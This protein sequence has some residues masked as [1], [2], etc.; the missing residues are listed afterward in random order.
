M[1]VAKYLADRKA[2]KIAKSIK[3]K[4]R[5]NR[6]F[7]VRQLDDEIEELSRTVYDLRR[8]DFCSYVGYKSSRVATLATKLY[9]VGGHTPCLI[10]FV[11]SFYQDYELQ[12]FLTQRNHTINIS[13]N[14]KIHLISDLVPIKGIDLN[15]RRVAKDIVNLFNL[16]VSAKP[17]I[18]FLY[19]HNDDV[20]A[21]AVV[22]LLRQKSD[23]KIIFFNHSDH[24]PV[25][26]M[27]F[28]HLILDA[29]SAAQHI[30]QEERGYQNSLIMPLQSQ[31]A[32]ANIYYSEDRL[33]AKRRELGIQ[34]DNLFTLSGFSAYKIFANDASPYISMIRDLLMQEPELKHVLVT[35]LSSKQKAILEEV[36]LNQE[37]A[38]SRL[39]IIS[40]VS[41]F[42]ILLQSCDLFIDSFPVGSALVHIDMM[43]NKR[44]TVVKIN[45]ENPIHS[46]EAYLPTDYAYVYA[47]VKAMEKGIRKLLND[48][49]EQKRVAMVLYQHYLRTFEFNVVKAKYLKVIENSAS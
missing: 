43:R 29:R 8:A 31:Q 36:F 1:I 2:S 14:E 13:C 49:L 7:D 23:I 47:D 41:D 17:R 48:K 45:R 37:E 12:C 9:N 16:I 40:R 5:R 35:E 4:F 30:T 19:I 21:S 42:D 22:A 27:K 26:G 20:V 24:L 3:S 33:I 25:L 6:S 28:A 15:K 39:I 44:P 10:N 34:K 46:F 32:N 38:R 11:R 18:L